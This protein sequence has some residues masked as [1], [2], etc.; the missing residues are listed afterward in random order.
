MFVFF[1]FWE[2][3]YHSIIISHIVIIIPPSCFLG[4]FVTKS[5]ITF[6][7]RRPFLLTE[8]YWFYLQTEC[9]ISYIIMYRHQQTNLDSYSTRYMVT[10]SHFDNKYLLSYYN[11]KLYYLLSKTTKLLT[12]FSLRTIFQVFFTS[13]A[14][15]CNQNAAYKNIILM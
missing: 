11:H 6:V 10:K 3:L 7:S 2:K 8:K 14:I 12:L 9:T 5:H 1:E 15:F 13:F 4:I